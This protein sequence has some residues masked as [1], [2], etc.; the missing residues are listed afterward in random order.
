VTIKVFTQQMCSSAASATGLVEMTRAYRFLSGAEVMNSGVE[1]H[2]IFHGHTSFELGHDFVDP[3]R[4]EG[5]CRA[6]ALPV[7][8]GVASHHGGVEWLALTEPSH[9]SKIG[10]G[11]ERAKALAKEVDSDGRGTIFCQDFFGNDRLCGRMDGRLPT[12]RRFGFQIQGNDPS[13]NGC[14]EDK[15]EKP[16]WDGINEE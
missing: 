2:V 16:S 1:F 10:G 13:L 12:M 5:P 3:R 15:E 11:G 6:S 9:Q 14:A 4:E 7:G 8:E